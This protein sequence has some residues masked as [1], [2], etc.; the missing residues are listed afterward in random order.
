RAGRQPWPW[1]LLWPINRRWEPP[2]KRPLLYPNE[3]VFLRQYHQTLLSRRVD[4]LALRTWIALEAGDIN[5]MRECERAILNLIQF[6][7]NKKLVGYYFL[8][9]PLMRLCLQRLEPRNWK[10]MEE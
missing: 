2:H 6:R 4:V 10:T 9:P 7:V 5:G 8:P 3:L 1:W